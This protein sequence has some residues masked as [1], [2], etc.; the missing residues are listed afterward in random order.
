M[1]K[2]L[3]AIVIVAAVFVGCSESVSNEERIASYN[4]RCL[5]LFDYLKDINRQSL[6]LD[7]IKEK[8]DAQFN[9]IGDFPTF[10]HTD[11]FDNIEVKTY[12]YYNKDSLV[13]IIMQVN[14]TDKSKYQTMTELF[15]NTET[16][17]K[18]LEYY[19]D[20]L[21]VGYLHG[22]KFVQLFPTPF[23]AGDD[24]M[25]FNLSIQRFQPDVWQKEREKQE[26]LKKE[27]MPSLARK[28]GLH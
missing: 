22:D 3:L 1:K 10:E 13:Q 4:N 18:Q 8:F 20:S 14:S 9:F 19:S 16:F 25:F 21:T 7:S 6:D 11:S 17:C 12:L 28:L 5:Q 23:S 24:G 26:R 27:P 15:R 2:I